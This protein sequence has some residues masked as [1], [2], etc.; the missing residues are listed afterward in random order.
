[1]DISESYPIYGDTIVIKSPERIRRRRFFKREA[2]RVI[3]SGSNW[4]KL[5][6]ASLFMSLTAVSVSYISDSFFAVMPANSY[7]ASYLTDILYLAV[8]VPLIYGFYAYC[9][10]LM[11]GTTPRFG[12]IFDVYGSVA[13]LARVY[14]IF[15][16]YLWRYFIWLAM[17]Y[18]GLF[19]GG[20][21]IIAAAVIFIGGGIFLQRYYLVP[22]IAL[23][24]MTVHEAVKCSVKLMKGYKFDILMFR[25]S[26]AVWFVISFLTLGVTAVMFV[27]PYYMLANLEFSK[28]IYN[29]KEI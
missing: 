1:M 7:A 8:I 27:I 29:T 22:Y 23:H 24:N 2:R 5:V 13:M 26:F 21:F 11:T 19:A 28:F 18:A 20:Y 16:V 3:F 6:F 9:G 15:F 17:I 4:Y 12:V 14:K 10:E 25:F